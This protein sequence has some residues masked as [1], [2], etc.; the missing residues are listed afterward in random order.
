MLVNSC[1]GV[2]GWMMVSWKEILM[3]H[4]M[5][6]DGMKAVYYSAHSNSFISLTI[7]FKGHNSGIP[8]LGAF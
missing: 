4:G 2:M 1:G 7:G 3:A 5:G 8:G 6:G